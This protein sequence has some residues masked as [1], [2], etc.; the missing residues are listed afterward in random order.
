ML[1]V[2]FRVDYPQ[3]PEKIKKGVVDLPEG[4]D[5][6]MSQGEYD[7][8]LIANQAGYDAFKVTQAQIAALQAGAAKFAAVRAK[9][10][11]IADRYATENSASG[12]TT[13]T[14]AGIADAFSN[15]E[16]Y[17]RLNVPTKAISEIDNISPIE[18]FLPQAKID[19]MKAEL[20]AFIQTTFNL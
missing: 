19:S 6:L 11:N 16:K 1:A 5:E 4:Y 20:L 3:W 12:I 13:A 9:W 2:K 14:A 15:V 7:D 8:Y 17:L 18:P 10:Q